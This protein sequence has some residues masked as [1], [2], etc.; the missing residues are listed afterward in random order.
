[1]SE[2]VS[3]STMAFEHLDRWKYDLDYDSS[4]LHGSKSPK[5]AL[6][7]KWCGRSSPPD[8]LRF[9]SCLVAVSPSF[10]D[11]V[12][13]EQIKGVVF[14]RMTMLV[15]GKDADYKLLQVIGEFDDAYFTRFDDYIAGN[16][17][18]TGLVLVGSDDQ[19]REILMMPRRRGGITI[20]VT[21]RVRKA[22]QKRKLRGITFTKSSDYESVVLD[23]V[24][25]RR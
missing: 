9:R 10:V 4:I 23:P 24:P 8:M 11:M 2:V 19:S 7:L 25:L 17:R 13:E 16:T 1:M 18:A 3:N 6:R 5:E 22:I 20:F 15:D 14:Q 12:R 21:G